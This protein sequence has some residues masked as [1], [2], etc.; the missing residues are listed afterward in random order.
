MVSKPTKLPAASPVA[1]KAMAVMIDGAAIKAP[2]NTPVPGS[3]RDENPS[4]FMCLLIS[5][6]LLVTV[7]DYPVMRRG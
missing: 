7:D 6:E 3:D 5:S 4:Y 1:A 2:P